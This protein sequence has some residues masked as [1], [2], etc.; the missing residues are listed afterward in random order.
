MMFGCG[1]GSNSDPPGAVSMFGSSESALLQVEMIKDFSPDLLSVTVGIQDN[2]TNPDPTV[3]T[4][5]LNRYRITYSRRDGGVGID[6]VE[7]IISETI[8][9]SGSF[10]D[11]VTFDIVAFHTDDKLYS[12]FA[13]DFLVNPNP[14]T[15]DCQV[16]IWGTSTSGDTRST[17]F[18]FEL[19]AGAYPPNTSLVP[20]INYFNQTTGIIYPGD[21]AANW[22]VEGEV[23]EGLFLFPWGDWQILSN[24]FFPLG[25][26]A[27]STGVLNLEPGTQLTTDSGVL[28]ASNRFG[29]TMTNENQT[30]TITAPDDP[31]TPVPDA[32]DILQFYSDKTEVFEG[33]E[34]T[35]YWVI[36]GDVEQLEILPEAF[37]GQVV[38]F[39]GLDLNFG[40]VTIRPT[41]SVRPI[42]KASN[43]DGL[44]NLFSSDTQFLE[45]AITVLAI[46][47]PTQPPSIDFF[48][49]DKTTVQVGRSVVFYWRVSGG[50]ERVELFPFN[51]NIFDVTD[52]SSLVSPP[53]FE[54]GVTNFSLIAFGTDGSIARQDITI[55]AVRTFNQNVT[56]TVDAVE[57]GTSINNT[58]QGSFTFIVADPERH[59]CSWRVDKIAGDSASFFPRDGQV[60]N[61]Q[62]PGLV[63]FTDGVDNDN[64]H[65]TFE[66]SAWDDDI[67]GFS[68][69]A[70]QAIEL[71]TFNTGGI[72][73]DTAPEITSLNFEPL[74]PATSP[75]TQGSLTFS[76]TDVDTLDL[77]WRLLTV[78]GDT[79]GSFSQSSGSV[80]TGS[81]QVQVNYTDDPDTP[82]D[83]VVILLRV[84][85]SHGPSPQHAILTLLIDKGSGAVTGGTGTT[86]GEP[87]GFPL[88]ALYGNFIGDPNS[89]ELLN[90]RTIYFNGDLNDPHFF[91][92][93]D[94]SGEVVG[95][96]F[97][98]DL[99][100]ESGDPGAINEVVFT[101]EFQIPTS[102]PGN[103]GSLTF[104]NYFAN[105][106]DR[107]GGS[108][109]PIGGGV[110]RYRMTFTVEDFRPSSNDAFNLPTTGSATYSVTITAGDTSANLISLPTNITVTV[111]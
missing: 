58:D 96:S 84:E 26:V 14:V 17:S 67:F 73:S 45:Q 111:P 9:S 41:Q 83:S 93:P 3:S 36:N 27:V 89:A 50:I 76:F 22:Y 11:S 107:T 43:S 47:D 49:T 95:L 103:D 82:T 71:L 104:V 101:R 29:S 18:G 60:P 39:T 25:A 80:D 15:F 94:L 59:D 88:A 30:I 110:G 42:L 102:A 98:V 34:V 97:V 38:D 91:R 78:S 5:N 31:P 79:G 8:A 19:V 24:S 53:F 23:S 100:H 37:N 63:R 40:S 81:G 1:G 65:L 55:S 69:A 54:E 62:G 13:R 77:N 44:G 68:G 75:G 57:P 51:G 66:I 7:G 32:V 109:T 92:N 72:L 105:S 2:L 52:V 64:G 35:L 106:G 20:N 16:T 61:G 86:T 6:N 99:S 12:A 4:I 10:A 108:A 21:Y 85:E 33:E 48:R 90:N 56:I 87:I 46:E 28:V 74:G 70:T